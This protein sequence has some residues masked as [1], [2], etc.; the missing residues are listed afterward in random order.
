MTQ[1]KLSIIKDYSEYSTVQGII[2]IFQD[3][4]TTF[5]KIFWSSVVSLMIL[6][7]C[8][9]SYLA[10]ADWQDN[11]VMT[12]VKNTAYPVKNLSFPAVTI[13]GQGNNED[14]LAAGRY[15]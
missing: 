1:G 11:P 5:G 10:Y 14:I 8:Y 6:L 3:N 15:K 7:G 9:W 4:Q 2:Y 13:C 12:T